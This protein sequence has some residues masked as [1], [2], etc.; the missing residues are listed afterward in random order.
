MLLRQ[1]LLLI[2]I[3]PQAA[4]M[5]SVCIDVFC[6][7]SESSQSNT[8]NCKHC[9]ETKVDLSDLRSEQSK[10]QQDN[11]E[12]N[13]TTIV[14]RSPF[15]TD[16]ERNRRLVSGQTFCRAVKKEIKVTNQGPVVQN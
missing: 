5:Y 6:L 15:E 1:S 2:L 4:N 7:I 13:Q 12:H 9:A 11:G 3:L 8:Y 14:R 10:H 16:S